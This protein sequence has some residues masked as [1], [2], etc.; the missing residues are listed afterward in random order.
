VPSCQPTIKNGL[1]LT[2]SGT[3][4]PELFSI[5]PELFSISAQYCASNIAADRIAKLPSSVILANR[6]IIFTD[7]T[8][9]PINENS[10]ANGK[11]LA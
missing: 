3:F 9:G 6:L 4:L 5:L 11:A 1:K 8:E 10:F 7:L 2:F